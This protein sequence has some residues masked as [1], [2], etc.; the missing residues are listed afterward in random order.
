MSKTLEAFSVWIGI[1]ITVNMLKKCVGLKRK[2]SP[3]QWLE[4]KKVCLA[5]QTHF[6]SSYMFLRVCQITEPALK[7][8]NIK[9]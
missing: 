6:L 8:T 1:T 7:V 5:Q 3:F 9:C 2:N 4:L